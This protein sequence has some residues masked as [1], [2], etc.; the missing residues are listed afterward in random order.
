MCEFHKYDFTKYKGEQSLIK[1][2]RNLVDYE[3]GN[4]ILNSAMNIE[5]KCLQ[6]NLF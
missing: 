6:I 2:A 1:I 5:K 4:I 3:A